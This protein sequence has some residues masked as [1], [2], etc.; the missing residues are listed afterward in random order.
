MAAEDARG[1]MPHAMTTRYHWSVSLRT[2]LGEAGKRLCTQA[3]FEWRLVMAEVA[4]AIRAYRVLSDSYGNVF[5]TPSAPDGWQFEAIADL[6]KPVCYQE[7]KCGFMAKFDRDCTIRSRVDDN[8]A[9]GRPSSEWGTD[10]LVAPGNP[11]VVYDS[12]GQRI[13]KA[14]RPEEWLADPGAAR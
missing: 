4:R 9:I 12:K 13:A 8:A 5:E 7:G 6:L 1:L 14:I 2:L 3:Q 10:S 11:H